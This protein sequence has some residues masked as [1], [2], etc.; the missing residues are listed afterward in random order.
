MERRY[1]SGYL[2]RLGNNTLPKNIILTQKIIVM[3]L[4]FR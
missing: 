1:F 2:E 4:V 3:L